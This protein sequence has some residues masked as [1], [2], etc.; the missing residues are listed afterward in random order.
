LHSLIVVMQ[1]PMRNCTYY[2][3]AHCSDTNAHVGKS[4]YSILVFKTN[5]NNTTTLTLFICWIFFFCFLSFWEIPVV[6]HFVVIWNGKLFRFQIMLSCFN[7]LYS[8]FSTSF[9][10]LVHSSLSQQTYCLYYETDLCLISE[11][12]FL[13]GHAWFLMGSFQ[14][15]FFF[16]EILLTFFSIL[17]SVPWL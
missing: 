5:N 13:P 7:V 17:S 6:L 14:S 1:M 11:T 9:I 15:A 16:S 4:E 8:T 10:N 3:N 2:A 12:S